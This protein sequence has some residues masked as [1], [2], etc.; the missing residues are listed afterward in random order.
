M[1]GREAWLLPVLALLAGLLAAGLVP[2]TPAR[3]ENGFA[4]YLTPFPPTD[5]YRLFLFGDSLAVGLTAPLTTDLGSQGIEVVNKTAPGLG[6]ARNDGTPWDKLIN[7]APATDD[8]QIA[9]VL[10]GTDDRAPMRGAKRWVAPGTPEWQQE[11]SSRVDAVLK[12]L[13]ARN[14]AIYWLG[15]P[16]MRGPLATA[17]AKTE[18]AVFLERV[19]LSGAKY[20]DSWDAFV[21]A[22]GAYADTG[23]DLTGN[24]KQMRLQDGIH[25]TPSGNQKL[26]SLIENEITK[27]L[28]IAKRER[29]VPLAGDETEQQNVR[30]ETLPR[31]GGAAK[32]GKAAKANASVKDYPADDGTVVVAG[33]DGTPVNIAIVRPPIPGAVIAQIVSNRA[34]QP[35]ELGHTMPT[36]LKGGFT[37]MSSIATS[38]DVGLK[39]QLPLT[40]NPFYKLLIRGDS[41]PSK[42]GRVDDFAWPRAG[43]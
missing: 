14:V 7:D 43:G 24:V 37:V 32:T 13:H 5:R 40:E 19:R 28:A 29:D 26:A 8:M 2:S 21:D 27:D 4:G 10:F 18:N 36:D 35:A 42:P 25:L 1:R 6:L 16:I 12:A 41:L 38:P 39:G 22:S 3:A 30:D 34:A 33:S 11:Y 17:A 15:L 20:I 23:P 31:A 9:V